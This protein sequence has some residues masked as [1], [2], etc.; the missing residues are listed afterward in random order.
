[1]VLP[2]F[3]FYFK[4]YSFAFIFPRLF[5]HYKTRESILFSIFNASLSVICYDRW[6]KIRNYALIFMENS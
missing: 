6:E 5:F 2:F 4:N 3:I 1:M